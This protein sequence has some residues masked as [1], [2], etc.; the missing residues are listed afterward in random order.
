MNYFE[1]T[2]GK[3][4]TIRIS[5]EEDFLGAVEQF[6]KETGMKYGVVVSGIATFKN[7]VMHMV[8]TT[9]YPPVEYFDRKEDTPLELSAVSGVIANGDIHLH[10]VV[11]DKDKAYSGHVEHGCQVLYLCELVIAEIPDGNFRRVKNEHGVNQLAA[12]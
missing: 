4:Y 9:T 11:S 6:V 7:C 12:L 5:P 1:G 3:V 8:T 10:M 2:L